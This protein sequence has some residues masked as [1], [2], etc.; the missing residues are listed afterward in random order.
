VNIAIEMTRTS[1]ATGGK[2]IDS[3]CV[4][5]SVVPIIRGTEWP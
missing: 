2:I 3:T 1:C 5:R 4:G